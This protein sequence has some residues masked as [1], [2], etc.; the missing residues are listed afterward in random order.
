MIVVRTNYDN[1]TA[2]LDGCAQELIRLV[3]SSISLDLGPPSNSISTNI[4]SQL[5]NSNSCKPLF[6]F[7]HGLLNPDALIAQDQQAAIDA[8]NDQL[9]K[10]RVVYAACCD[11][12]AI[13]ANAVNTHKATVIGYN[14]KLKVPL[15]RR[16]RRLMEHCVLA[17]AKILVLNRQNAQD[18]RDGLEQAFRGAAQQLIATGK[19]ADAVIGVRVFDANATITAL[20]GD[21]NRTI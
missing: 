7:G 3:G 14:G 6:F 5:Q 15:P 1:V 13:L 12:M 17:G 20:A 11:G 2:I 4:H 19:V 9:L 10:D 21:P 8:S 16:Y 18:A